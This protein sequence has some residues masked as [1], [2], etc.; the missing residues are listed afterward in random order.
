M[1]IQS[2]VNKRIFIRDVF[3]HRRYTVYL[4]AHAESATSPPTLFLQKTLR[5]YANLTTHS[6]RGKVGHVPTRAHRGY[7]TGAQRRVTSF[8]RRTRTTLPLYAIAPTGQA[9]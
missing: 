3:M 5:N 6:G 8:M 7:A 4:Q 9:K 1:D 2:A